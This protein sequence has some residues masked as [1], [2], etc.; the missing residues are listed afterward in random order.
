MEELAFSDPENIDL[1]TAF[2]QSK[3]AK[4][5]LLKGLQGETEGFE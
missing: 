4:L 3:L 2:S 5:R 1:Q